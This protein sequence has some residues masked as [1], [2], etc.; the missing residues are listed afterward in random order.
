MA[1]RSIT[2]QFGPWRASPGLAGDLRKAATALRLIGCHPLCSL[3]DELIEQACAVAAL[4]V[5][6]CAE[7]KRPEVSWQHGTAGANH[8]LTFRLRLS[9]LESNS[10]AAKRLARS[11]VNCCGQRFSLGSTL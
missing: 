11:A 10:L 6:R 4:R 2:S 3:A 9:L 5:A 8:G 1:Q 7:K